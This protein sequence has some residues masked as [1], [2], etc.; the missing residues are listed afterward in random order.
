MPD[1][2]SETSDPVNDPT[3]I[4][5]AVGIGA[6]AG[7]L[8]SL[9]A[10]FKD[11]PAG[12][13]AC[14]I[15]VQHMMPDIESNLNDILSRT[16]SLPI[17]DIEEG[18][19]ICADTI[20]MIRPG[21][22]I[23]LVGR[24]F[25]VTDRDRDAIS[26]PVDG[27]FDS[28]ATSFGGN[29]IGIILSGTGSDGSDGVKA[30]REAGGITI[31]ESPK[32]A[33]FDGMPR[34]AIAT[35]CI[36]FIVPCQSIGTW[37]IKQFKTPRERQAP[38]KDLDE[39][40]LS[41]IKLIF[42]LLTKRHEIDFS[43]YKPNT[44]ARRIERRCQLAHC[45]STVKFA[46]MIQ[47]DVEELDRLYHDLL[48]GVTKFFRDT[49]AFNTLREHVER[50]IE[51][52]TPDEEFR[53]W[54]AG[55]AS[56]EEA[57]SVAMIVH[58]AYRKID[59][60]PNY[61][62]FATDAHG[63]ALESASRGTYSRDSME[64]VGE[65]LRRRYFTEDASGQFRIGSVLR[66]Q[67]VFARHNVI[68]DPPFT[69]LDLVTCRNMLIYFQ[70]PAQRSAI[71]TFHF[72]LRKGG[73]LFLGCSE[74][75]G[76]LADEFDVISEQWHLYLKRRHVSNLAGKWSDKHNQIDLAPRK[77][78]NILNKDR[79][80]TLSFTSLIDGYDT[81]LREYVKAGLLLD[82]KRNILHV[83]GDAKKYLRSKSGRFT[84]NVMD[85]LEKEARIE[86]AAALIRAEGLKGRKIIIENVKLRVE[87][88]VE[89]R[90]VHVKA[91]PETNWQASMWFVEFHAPKHEERKVEEPPVRINLSGQDYSTLESELLY[92]KENLS[93]TIEELEVSNEELQSSNEQ[94]IASNEELQS[95]NEELH[96]VNEE[97]Y[98]VNSENKRKIEELEQVTDDVENLL[99]N[100]DIGT[101]LLDSDMRIRRYTQAAQQYVKLL[102]S[103]IGRLITDFAMRI[104]A[105]DLYSK[106]QEVISTGDPYSE[107][108]RD[109]EDRETLVK[110]VPYMSGN[111]VSGAI[112]NFIQSD[113]PRN[114]AGNQEDETQP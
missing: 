111:V 76:K 63:G 22:T 13:G 9:E 103:D 14:F 60:E 35:D 8:K 56:G 101:I 16:T 5:F 1:T 102:P 68:K 33:Q 98:S 45:Q 109:G 38:A 113:K 2:H 30:I 81:I 69:K 65:D 62:I 39:Q 90:D 11:I 46:E 91:F 78:I 85:F 114:D 32:T 28:L 64:Y 43:H 80:E 73:M 19:E 72:G 92:T 26:R 51:E 105:A 27:L 53:V 52:K 41:G 54:V 44:V 17:V 87:N 7:G 107:S 42:S 75:P 67:L 40:E 6:S 18:V 84:G 24:T 61:K 12:S 23:E 15:I 3:L 83:F 49:E 31:A 70:P 71:S 4:N 66:R 99:A 94:L 74:T 112:V 89:C 25:T 59:R 36:D 57:Y 82:D 58:E 104:R 29:S 110:I 86:L 106:I 77:L 88:E 96:S 97:L 50:V 95:T 47:G 21:T 108:V 34:N 93:S 10:L 55:C 48:I 37:L 100:T 20:F 79:P